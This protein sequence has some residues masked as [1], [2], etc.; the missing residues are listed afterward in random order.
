MPSR[1]VSSINN[2]IRHRFK[3]WSVISLCC[4][5]LLGCASAPKVS[6]TKG[7]DLL[8]ASPN[9]DDR[10]P[11]FVVIH[12]TTNDTAE[13]ALKTLTNPVL[14]VSAH[15]LISRDGKVYRLV[16]EMRRAW[17][18]GVS[19][20]GGNTDLNSSSIGIELDNNGDEPFAEAQISRLL[21][22]LKELKLKYSIPAANFIGH[23]DIAPGRK[24]DPGRLFPWQ[25]LAGEGFGLWCRQA[26]LFVGKGVT[27]EVMALQALGYNVTTP[28][29]AVRAFRR[30]FLASDAEGS[31]TTTERE[32]LACLI[33]EKRQTEASPEKSTP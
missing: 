6:S 31:I 30:H 17:H 27:D 5:T 25:R 23:G 4:L 8:P 33:A 28:A 10:K 13:F 2:H 32:Q 24:V 1:P 26:N 29:K 20:W 7:S 3:V 16:D 12:E 19:Y 18:A 11:N 22:L 9:F 15:Y 21:I 14:K